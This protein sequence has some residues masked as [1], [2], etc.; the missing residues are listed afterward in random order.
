MDALSR[1][2]YK[3]TS[4]ELGV[5]NFLFYAYEKTSKKDRDKEIVFLEHSIHVPSNS[6][7]RQFSLELLLREVRLLASWY[8]QIGV[9]A[10]DCIALYMPN[11]FEI[12]LHHLALNSLGAIPV[13]TNGKLPVEDALR[14]FNK[15]R[16]KG[17]IVGSQQEKNLNLAN[18]NLNYFVKLHNDILVSNEELPVLYP[19][20]HHKSSPILISHTSGTTGEVKGVVQRHYNFFFGI[21]KFLENRPEFSYLSNPNA[22]HEYLSLLPI[23]HN[24]FLA[25]FMR[26]ILTGSKLVV[27]S[28]HH[29]GV[30]IENIAHFRP[31][32]IVGFFQTFQNLINAN[33]DP[34]KLCSVSYWIN[35]GDAAHKAYIKKII[36]YGFH[37]HE[38]SL[39]KGSVFLDGLG[40][41]EMGSTF[42]RAEHSKYHD[43]P[44]RCIGLLRPWFDA[45]IL[46]EKG[47]NLP[48]YTVGMLGVKGETVTTGYWNDS[49]LI[50]K[51]SLGG[52][53]LTGDL[54]YK[55]DRNQYF[56]VD[57]ITDQIKTELGPVYSLQT[58]DVIFEAIP[59]LQECAVVDHG[60]LEA[61]AY[62][63]L[64]EPC[65]NE[66]ILLDLINKS[67]EAHQLNP[68]QQ[69]VV[70]EEGRMPRGVTGK[71]L[72]RNLRESAKSCTFENVVL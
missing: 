13:Y 16:I 29:P 30:V 60:N 20:Q 28:D 50:E 26:A 68:I 34:E 62:L 44:I 11:S 2:T 32:V 64:G 51:A 14:Y 8:H 25:Y 39:E 9:E 70:L 1:Y 61:I 7:Q 5:G 42:F 38:K 59:G 6:Y 31:Q 23:A 4:L 27:L 41:S 10:L 21:E 17:V 46:D 45:S 54:A 15:I 35:T 65:E 18:K 22:L 47:N 66:I 24:S 58:E 55:N 69:V 40:S 48:N 19:F 67:L 63:E 43:L 49:Q 33:P 52:Y 37:M 12:T 56:L 57:R 71:V 36:Q 53:W 3:N 72:K